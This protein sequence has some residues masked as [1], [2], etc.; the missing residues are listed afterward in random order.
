MPCDIQN[1]GIKE[2]HLCSRFPVPFKRPLFRL[3]TLGTYVPR[4]QKICGCKKLES[5]KG[6][7]G[8]LKLQRTHHRLANRERNISARKRVKTEMRS[9][10]GNEKLTSLMLLYTQNDTVMEI[11]N[12]ELIND[13]FE[14]NHSFSK[15]NLVVQ[16]Q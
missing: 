16:A 11:V 10:I 9:T 12:N 6:E 7:G 1:P 15:K 2:F 3:G 14:K 4:A 5:E 8:K 13:L